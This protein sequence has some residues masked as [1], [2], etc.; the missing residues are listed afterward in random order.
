M[1]IWD[2]VPM[3]NFIVPVLHIQIGRGYNILINHLDFVNS[4]VDRL[5]TVEEVAH[6]TMMTVNQVNAKRRQ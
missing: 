3:N 5:S 2:S 6:N 1:A 4:D